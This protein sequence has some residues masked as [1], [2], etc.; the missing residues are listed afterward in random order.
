MESCDFASNGG[1]IWQYATIIPS[2]GHDYHHSVQT[3]LREQEEL[4]L[5]KWKA[6]LSQKLEKALN[7]NESEKEETISY[8]MTPYRKWLPYWILLSKIYL[9]A[10]HRDNNI[11]VA[12]CEGDFSYVVNFISVQNTIARSVTNEFIAKKIIKRRK[13]TSRTTRDIIQT[14][15]PHT[16]WRHRWIRLLQTPDSP[17]LLTG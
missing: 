2:V 1:L 14:K 9:F 11:P 10:N 13:T 8:P 6:S 12:A 7:K 17:T 3:T 16:L 5:K 4:F 15:R